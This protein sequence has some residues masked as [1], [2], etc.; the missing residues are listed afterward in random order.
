MVWIHGGSF[1]LGSARLSEYDGSFLA[2]KHGVVV[3]T[4]NYRTNGART[5]SKTFLGID[6]N[7]T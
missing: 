4:M 6:L 2:A 7:L 1:Q 3:V 5:F